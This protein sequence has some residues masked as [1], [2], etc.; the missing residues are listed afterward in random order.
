[1][2]DLSF[3]RIPE[4][5]VLYC[6]EPCR[7]FAL[8]RHCSTEPRSGFRPMRVT[9][10][11]RS[12]PGRLGRDPEG[13]GAPASTRSI[14]LEADALLLRDIAAL[15]IGRRSGQW[16]S[17]SEGAVGRGKN[18]LSP[19]CAEPSDFSPVRPMTGPSPY[20]ERAYAPSLRPEDVR[21]RPSDQRK[22]ASPTAGS[23]GPIQREIRRLKP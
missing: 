17:A 6:A 1:M 21:A 13:A 7:C 10:T 15:T 20:R 19:L 11:L 8:T 16:A 3:E 18:R 12:S 22:K 14:R 2:F 9:I 4:G 23:K 5:N